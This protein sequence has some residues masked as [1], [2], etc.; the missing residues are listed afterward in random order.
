[1]REKSPELLTEKQWQLEFGLSYNFV[2]TVDQKF[3]DKSPL[4][5][6]RSDEFQR[7]N[8]LVGM[9]SHEGFYFIIYDFPDRFDPRIESYNKNITIEEY[10]Q[11]VKKLKLKLVDS[12]SDVVSDTIASIYSLPCG[13]EG[14]TGD[15]DVVSYIRALDGM[16]GD[17]R[18]KCPV[19]RMTKAYARQ[20]GRFLPVFVVFHNF[21]TSALMTK[22]V[23]DNVL[24]L[25]LNCAEY[26]WLQ[27]ILLPGNRIRLTIIILVA[28]FWQ[29]YIVIHKLF[30]VVYY[31]YKLPIKPIPVRVICLFSLS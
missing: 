5:V 11:L 4:E 21:K 1:M 3:L 12:S 28:I 13:S 18:F 15:V 20:V 24:Y 26:C 25:L 16:Y 10:R 29:C 2:P 17:V 6:I 19:I 8:I 30:F 23:L 9:N 14:N 22:R 27:R 7:K 31:D